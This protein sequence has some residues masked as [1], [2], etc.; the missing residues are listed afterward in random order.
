[1]FGLQGFNE[2]NTENHCDNAQKRKDGFSD[3]HSAYKNKKSDEKGLF[4]QKQVTIMNSDI[5]VDSLVDII[6]RQHRIRQYRKKTKEKA[7]FPPGEAA[8]F[9]AVKKLNKKIGE[10]S[11]HLSKDVV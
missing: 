6:C 3:F 7:V 4:L 5:K 2:K 1:M 10:S 9:R 11:L 8:F